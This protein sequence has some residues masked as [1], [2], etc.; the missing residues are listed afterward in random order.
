MLPNDLHFMYCQNARKQMQIIN[1]Q[2][3]KRTRKWVAI[4]LSFQCHFIAVDFF[5]FLFSNFVSWSC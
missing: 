5:S 1:V 2:Q 4:V 3:V